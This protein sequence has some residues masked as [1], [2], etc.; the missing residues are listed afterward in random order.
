MMR[1]QP[2]GIKRGRLLQ[3]LEILT[4]SNSRSSAT[5]GNE[6]SKKWAA[7]CPNNFGFSDAAGVL[8]ALIQD[9]NLNG[10]HQIRMD[11]AAKIPVED[12]WLALD[13]FMALRLAMEAPVEVVEVTETRR[14][15]VVATITRIAV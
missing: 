2:K 1:L 6:F 4:D 15:E 5:S 7:N 9:G 10:I 3:A 12:P 13:A 11:P 8:I 14:K